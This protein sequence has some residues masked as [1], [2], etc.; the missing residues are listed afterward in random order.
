[1]T[2]KFHVGQRVRVVEGNEYI[3]KESRHGPG[4]PIQVGSLGTIVRIRTKDDTFDKREP[5]WA[6]AV[7]YDDAYDT[8]F[9]WWTGLDE[10]EPADE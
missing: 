5:R 2:D 8:G 1:M 9:P 7:D 3:D 6:L 4:R 10:V